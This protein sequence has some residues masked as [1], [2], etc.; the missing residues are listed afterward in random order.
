M[1]SIEH[2][3]SELF[4]GSAVTTLVV[5]TGKGSPRGKESD[6]ISKVVEMLI[7][8]TATRQTYTFMRVL[9]GIP[10]AIEALGWILDRCE[11]RATK[12]LSGLSPPIA[13]ESVVSVETRASDNA[14]L[15]RCAGH[16]RLVEAAPVSA[17]KTGSILMALRA[18]IFPRNALPNLF[19]DT[20][21]GEPYGADEP[22]WAVHGVGSIGDYMDAQLG[23]SRGIVAA[24]R[25]ELCALQGEVGKLLRGYEAAINGGQTI[26]IPGWAGLDFVHGGGVG[27]RRFQRR[28]SRLAGG[29]PL[30][31]CVKLAVSKRHTGC[32]GGTGFG[33]FAGRCP[34]DVRL[35]RFFFGSTDRLWSTVRQVDGCQGH[36]S[37]ENEGTGQIG[38]L[39][40]L[41]LFVKG[42]KRDEVRVAVD[43]GERRN[44]D[45]G[46]PLCGVHN[47]G[48]LPG[49]VF[50]K[51]K[52]PSK[53]ARARHGAN[54]AKQGN[55]ASRD[56]VEPCAVEIDHV[57]P[58]CWHKRDGRF[59]GH[60]GQLDRLIVDALF[61]REVLNDEIPN[62]D[63][64]RGHFQLC[65]HR[66]S[67][68]PT[69][70]SLA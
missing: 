47:A 41:L 69:T 46:C 22:A 51:H 13:L 15:L 17:K 48:V 44:V 62:L 35:A 45:H 26:Q 64:W 23:D 2:L 8:T 27:C 24:E 58:R 11:Q 31:G 19:F 33:G 9:S 49:V 59:H 10:A 53:L 16:E 25:A 4:T 36:N 54:V 56:V 68:A 43:G 28:C 66:R 37:R 38:C 34:A 57:L 65:D 55:A 42:K 18:C 7:Q 6:L 39:D 29:R 67:V 5:A 12:F 20:A 32:R 61:K 70:E 14:I 40:R 1:S 21:L 50:R 60:V 3:A 63:V 30:L 52:A